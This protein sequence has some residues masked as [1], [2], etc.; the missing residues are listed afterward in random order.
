MDNLNTVRLVLLL[1]CLS[2]CLFIAIRPPPGRIGQSLRTVLMLG[3]CWV[4]GDL[5]R[6]NAESFTAA[7]LA[8]TV[9]YT[10][11]LWLPPNLILLAL[12][13]SRQLERPLPTAFRKLV[14]VGFYV[15][16]VL[17]IA[18]VTNPLHWKFAVP[19]LGAREI[20]G[21][22]WAIQAWI[23]NLTSLVA[24]TLYVY[25]WRR[26]PDAVARRQVICVMTAAMLPTLGGL[27]YVLTP[28]PL[29]LNPSI[30]G[31]AL[32]SWMFVVGIR[33]SQLLSLL[34]SVMSEVITHHSDG[35]VLVDSS[36]HLIHANPAADHFVEQ[37]KIQAGG[38]FY[39]LITKDLW[40]HADPS[41]HVDASQFARWVNGFD[42]GH[43]GPR[44]YRLISGV[45]RIIEI[46]ATSIPNRQGGNICHCLRLRDITEPM[47]VE[48][49]IARR[50]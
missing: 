14:K 47:L 4:G 16:A 50:E 31:I 29:P 39:E 20:H 26:L 34:P 9:T 8:L 45:S 25:L 38:S 17:W 12:R 46:E 27:I 49:R 40:T 1:W 24:M 6:A 15:S 11:I 33:R 2:L 44:R 35:L 30:L 10:G 28:T 41:T 18:L 13:F 22:I 19:Q 32:G 3:A 7:N 21:P 37:R 43:P 42:D 36:G 48:E 5:M 23:G